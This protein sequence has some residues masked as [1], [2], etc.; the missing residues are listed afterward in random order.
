VTRVEG[1]LSKTTPPPAPDPFQSVSTKPDALPP[2][3]LDPIWR[4][5]NQGDGIVDLP[6]GIN[7]SRIKVNYAE[8]EYWQNGGKRLRMNVTFDTEVIV[9]GGKPYL[10]MYVWPG[11][12]GDYNVRMHYRTA[13]GRTQA[14]L[15]SVHHRLTNA[16]PTI[17]MPPVQTWARNTPAVP[18]DVR[19][20]D[21]DFSSDGVEARGRYR[22]DANSPWVPFALPTN[23]EGRP[24]FDPSGA[25]SAAGTYEISVI[26]TDPFGRRVS[27]NSQINIVENLA[28]PL[29]SLKPKF[30]IPAPENDTTHDIKLG[31]ADADT[32]LSKINVEIIGEQWVSDHNCEQCYRKIQTTLRRTT[33]GYDIGVP[34]PRNAQARTRLRILVRDPSNHRV[35]VETQLLTTLANRAPEI[36]F[37]G[38]TK[39]YTQTAPVRI[40]LRVRDANRDALDLNLT[41]S[42]KPTTGKPRTI[43]AKIIRDGYNQFVELR[44]PQSG[45][46]TVK[47]VASERADNGLK[48]EKSFVLNVRKSL[49]A[50]TYLWS[51]ENERS[52]PSRS[53][54]RFAPL[55]LIRSNGRS[56]RS[57]NIWVPGSFA[58][59]TKPRDRHSTP[60][61][62]HPSFTRAM[63]YDAI[64][65]LIKTYN[66]ANLGMSFE[67]VLT[68]DGRR[69]Y[70][71]INVNDSDEVNASYDPNDG[72]ISTGTSKGKWD[73][74]ADKDIVK[75]EGG[76]LLL[77]H[78]MRLM[79]NLVGRAIH[80]GYG[81]AQASLMHGDPEI[82]EDIAKARPSSYLRSAKN[83]ATISSTSTEAHSRGRV[84]A[85]IFWEMGEFFHKK[86]TGRPWIQGE[87]LE[88][89]A[90]LQALKILWTFALFIGTR[91]PTTGD[92]VRSVTRA[93][94]SLHR[95][96]RFDPRIGKREIS[97]LL[98]LF[99]SE[100]RKRGLSTKRMNGAPKLAGQPTTVEVALQN[101]LI[102]LG[103]NPTQ[104]PA[105]L[106][107][108]LHGPDGEIIRRYDVSEWV[109][110]GDQ[111]VEIPIEDGGI[112]IIQQRNG[113]I[114]TQS[115]DFTAHLRPRDQTA[116]SDAIRSDRRPPRLPADMIAEAKSALIDAATIDAN[117][118][119]S[120][121]G[122]LDEHSAL[123]A[124][125]AGR[126]ALEALALDSTEA[127]LVWRA[128]I[129]CVRVDLGSVAYVA[130]VKLDGSLAP[131]QRETLLICDLRP[132]M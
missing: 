43:S 49:Y 11:F 93:I 72:K 108:T 42:F 45:T 35:A 26:Y 53:K 125:N 119:N 124:S 67:R 100:A 17:Q 105:R 109:Y 21:A 10:R 97:D 36:F 118:L 73:L 32:P 77:D 78:Q 69:R 63:A 61:E 38:D 12:N 111:L 28:A 113:S 80:E 99:N 110:V 58:K 57:R 25:Q 18:L 129:L 89:V 121:D 22:K 60:T 116:P 5:G 20:R 37:D 132:E 130:P 106:T 3:I 52:S 112:S 54:L 44:I 122:P 95:S 14:A 9:K 91:K 2:A 33:T 102:D 8:M 59:G 117:Q 92:F 120:T 87:Q 15:I 71:I 46:Y 81:D 66:A 86:I 27:G 128:G 98:A 48:T 75:H 30:E 24:V 16:R 70:V 126:Q 83:R 51:A 39:A 88:P 84:F 34:V 40:P 114:E 64:W 56:L 31:I 123:S 65:D 76:H 82:G 103:L 107:T 131:L 85:G 62:N 90:R 7:G 29:V 4:L 19:V 101:S 96:G 23:R 41:A 47:L 104:T 115:D 68:A 94:N 1:S 74:G 50:A 6:L 13:Q 79:F 55:S 127:R